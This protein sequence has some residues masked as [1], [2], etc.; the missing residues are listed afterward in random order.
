MLALSK[1][2]EDKLDIAKARD[3]AGIAKDMSSVM[4]NMETDNSNNPTEKAGPTFIFYTPKVKAEEN[5]DVVQA[6][7]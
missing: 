1:L 7:E 3:L 2:T 6:K 4:K 5:F